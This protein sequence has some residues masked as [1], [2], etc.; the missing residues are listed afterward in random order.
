[1]AARE[2]GANRATV[3]KYANSGDTPFGDER[4][5]VG[6]GAVVFWHEEGDKPAPP[7][8]LPSTEPLSPP[9]SDEPLH[10]RPEQRARLLEMARESIACLLDY[11]FAP[12]YKVTDEE[13][14]HLSGAFVTLKEEGRLRGCIGYILPRRPLY[15]A[16]QSAALAAA[17]QDPRFPPLAREELDKVEIEISVLSPL[18]RLDDPEKLEVGKHGIMIVKG[19]ASGL[20]LPQVAVEEGWDREEFLRGVCHKAGLPE[21]AWKD[22]DAELYVFTAEVF[23]EKQ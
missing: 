4:Q 20:L 1:M 13:L 3:V 18:H 10:L 6:Y 5:V 23:G 9:P 17:F 15:L 19:G 7:P 12:L 2:L 22:K 16:V 21:D 11:G 8:D 14:L